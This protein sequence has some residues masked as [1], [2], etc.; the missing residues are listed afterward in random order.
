MSMAELCAEQPDEFKVYLEYC[1]ALRF[2][3]C[4][5]YDYLRRLFQDLMKR[6]VRNGFGK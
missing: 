5:N 4:P 1:R 2:E 3:D 6:K